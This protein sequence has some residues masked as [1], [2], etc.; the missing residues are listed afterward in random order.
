MATRQ[1]TPN[2]MAEIDIMGD[3]L[4]AGEPTLSV[5]WHGKE[6]DYP[7]DRI[8]VGKRMR[9][10]GDITTLTESIS[11]IGLLNP[12]NILPDG[13]LIA[14]NHRVAAARALGWTTIRVRVVELSEV[15]AELAEIDE[16]LRRNNL[17]V[18]E[19]SEHLLRREE[20]LEAKGMRAPANRPEK[21]DTVS[22]FST[23]AD[24]ADGMGMT[25]RSAQR[26]LQ[27]AKGLDGEA[28]ALIRGNEEIVNSTTQLLEL[29]RQPAER[30]RTIADLLM[31]GKASNVND[32]VR[33]LSPVQAPVTVKPATRGYASV[34]QLE[35]VVREI[36]CRSEDLRH[37]ANDGDSDWM[38][39]TIV[40]LMDGRDYQWK[41]SD[42]V[43]A[44]N[45]V[46]AQKEVKEAAD[47]A[48][49]VAP[50]LAPITR[51][52]SVPAPI[53]Y[54]SDVEAIII[55]WHRSGTHDVFR[56]D[57]LVLIEF[58]IKACANRNFQISGNMAHQAMM[59]ARNL[60]VA[61]KREAQ[62]APGWEGV[63]ARSTAPAPTLAPV[64]LEN[65]KNLVDWTEEDWSE[66]E[67]KIVP[68]PEVAALN[69]KRREDAV[70]LIEIYKLVIR[71][72]DDY[73]KAT[74]DHMTPLPVTEGLRRM[75]ITLERLVADLS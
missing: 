15:D 25:E 4:A 67:A 11:Q 18:L 53:K 41:K 12:V 23:T 74:G 57:D 39:R 9:P 32:A 58:I 71:R 73:T 70:D 5:S 46:A 13:T 50:T 28:K 38:W 61:D 51:P 68:S 64:S 7:I 21:G 44:V 65:G 42:L 26:R 47:E 22:P 3:I 2:L 60:I 33:L 30:Q 66:A 31:S 19:E 17:T 69:A 48:A 56:L 59:N 16:N 8:R 55:E 49:A 27:I 36:V 24:I 35:G 43:Q 14:G 6:L 1:P 54:L 62:R 75:I 72:E 52:E 63:A 37:A 34:W 40:G 45:N 29:A 20:L 10:L